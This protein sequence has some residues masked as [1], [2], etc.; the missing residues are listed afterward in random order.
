MTTKPKQNPDRPF[1]PFR[2]AH[3][4]ACRGLVADVLNQ[5]QG[6]ENNKQTRKRSRK[7]RDQA[8]LEKQIEA[9]VSDLVHRYL[10]APEGWIAV[11]MSNQKLCSKDIYRSELLNKTFPTVVKVLASPELAFAELVLGNHSERRQTT[12]K[13]GKRLI[14]R[15]KDRGLAPSDLGIDKSSEPIVLRRSKITGEKKAK[16]IN[17]V[18]TPDTKRYRQ[19]M[20]QINE[21][22]ANADI[23]YHGKDTTV[24][25]TT[26][27]LRRIFNNGS[28]DLGGRLYGGFWQWMKSEDRDWITIDDE[29]VTCLDYGQIG[30]YIAYSLCGETPEFD[31][32]Y[33]IP[34][35]IGDRELIKK[36]V[37]KLYN[38]EASPKKLPKGIHLEPT[39]INWAFLTKDGRTFTAKERARI[40]A[41]FA[42]GFVNQYHP[43]IGKLYLQKN[44]LSFMNL[45]SQIMIQ[46]ILDLNSQN[47]TALPIHD[48][49]L[50][51]ASVV[52]D[53][54]KRMRAA[55]K[56]ILNLDVPIS[57]D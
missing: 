42:A 2:K 48:A 43:K 1:N 23:Q 26:R 57:V 28:F 36:F 41:E 52:N 53:A 32:G 34:E 54:E 19:E 21:Y 35:L 33:A 50:V 47:I 13:A 12:I 5:F 18:D 22:L 45:E 8:I 39:S 56:K 14:S 44:S 15:I 55:A 25:E 29:E 24:D 40:E 20:N 46:L 37:N 51:K 38:S 9:L 31:D 27:Y 30:L 49:V 4:E 17:Y 3:S 16:N 10:T 11:T 6:Y 7:S